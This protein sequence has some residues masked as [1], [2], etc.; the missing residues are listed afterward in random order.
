MPRTLVCRQQNIWCCNSALLGLQAAGVT[1]NADGWAGQLD[2]EEQQGQPPR[3]LE[4]SAP[5]PRRVYILMGGSGAERDC[6]IAPG[7]NAFLALDSLEG[8]QVRALETWPSAAARPAGSSR[9][10]R[11]ALSSCLAFSGQPPPLV[12]I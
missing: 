2:G 3:S 4:N 11:S 10:L 5:W 12:V 1:D 6:S 7:V 9:P 8:Y